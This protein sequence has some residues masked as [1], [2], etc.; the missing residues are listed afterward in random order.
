MVEKERR[1]LRIT[2][3]GDS[4]GGLYH[5]VTIIGEGG[6]HDDLDCL[7]FKT[8][9]TSRVEG[10]IKTEAFRVTGQSWVKGLEAE[11]LRIYGKVDFDGHVLCRDVKI[12]GEAEISGGLTGETIDLKGNVLVKE[13]VEA[14]T[15]HAKGGFSIDGL[16]NAGNIEIT[17]KFS[18]SV[19]EIGGGKVRVR[20]GGLPFEW[21]PKAFHTMKTATLSVDMIEG[22]EIDLENTSAKVVRGKNVRIGPG[23]SVDL[24]EYQDEFKQDP[25]AKVDENRKI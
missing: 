15:F 24:V 8:R 6:I 13:N 4:R 9:G 14:E 16:L 17:L 10:H 22:D 5:K 12:R 21:T 18:S 2:G 11:K 3:S 7:V 19:K 25:E 23:C 20:R 1:N